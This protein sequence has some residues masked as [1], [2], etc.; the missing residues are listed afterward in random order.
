MDTELNTYIDK[1]WYELIK[2]WDWYYIL[3][4]NNVK[5]IFVN[6]WNVNKSFFEKLKPTLISFRW[7]NNYTKMMI[8]SLKNYIKANPESIIVDWWCR[9]A[10][11]V[12]EY[13]LKWIN[14]QI[15]AYKN[16]WKWWSTFNFTSTFISNYL[17]KKDL[18]KNKNITLKKWAKKE[19]KDNY[20]LQFMEFPWSLS[21]IVIKIENWEL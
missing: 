8:L 12:N 20:A 21:D 18:Y 14:N 2:E 1:F 10:S 5:V 6:Y 4:K 15:V 17:R 7:H 19:L 13:R 3:D 16:I 11:L 9:N